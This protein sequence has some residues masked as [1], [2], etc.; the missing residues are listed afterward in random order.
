MRQLLRASFSDATDPPREGVMN[1]FSHRHLLLR[2]HLLESEGIKCNFCDIIISGWAYACEKQCTYLHDLCSNFPREIR[3]DFHPG[4]DHT[5]ILRPFQSRSGR[6][7]FRCDACGSGDSDETLFQSYY[8]CE[9]C[10]FNLHVECASIPIAL[11]QKVRYPLHLFL[12]FPITSE[13]ATPFCSICAKVVPTSGCWVFYS[14]DHDYLCHFDCAA[15]AE[16]GMEKDSMGKLQNRVQSL[17]ITNCPPARPS[18]PC[19]GVKH[20]THRHSLKEYNLEMPLSCSL[21][22][23]AD[24]SGYFCSGCNYFIDKICFSI[25]SKIQHMSHPQHPLKFTPF[26]DLVHEDLKCS[27]CLADFKYRGMAYY[28]APCKFSI[29]FY[30]AGAPKTLTLVDNVS[31]E[32]FFSFPFKHEN[33]EIE[34]NFK[35]ASV[36]PLTCYKS[37]AIRP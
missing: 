27:G 22:N 14:H 12:S 30:C 15:V 37:Q 23:F 16:Y 9:S 26:L 17:A 11:N 34:C 13:A 33:A 29:E 4:F 18:Q 21:C 31:Y 10:N 20:F 19:G 2:L 24:S 1:H 36:G 6:E 7:Q 5:L 32:L 8:C 28:C 25:P 3:H 35:L